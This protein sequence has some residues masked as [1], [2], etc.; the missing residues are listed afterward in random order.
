MNFLRKLT[1]VAGAATV[2]MGL[3]A[4]PAVLYAAP[5]SVSV[6]LPGD[7]P[8]LDP[9]KDTS[10]L[11]FNYRLN[12]FDALTELQRDGQMNPRLAESWTVSP[13]LLE[14]TFKLRQNVKFHDGSPFTADDVV[15][16]VERILNDSKSPVRTF[17]K[18]VKTVEKVDDN[19]V[20]FTLSAPYGIFY[21]QISYVN[22]MSKTYFDKVGDQG[23]AT[24][25]VGTG[26]YQLV[27][28]KKDDRMVLKAN[29][30]YW[31]G[32]PAIKDAT[33]RPIPADASRV[34]ALLTGEVDLVPALPP[35]LMA[36]VKASPDLNV[37]I[38]PG[39]RVIFVAFN[40]NKPPFDNPL[41]REAVDKAIDRPAI[42]D[43]LLRGLGKPTGI[44]VPPMNIGYDSSLAPTK[45]DPA[46]AKALV[47]K[48]GYKGEVISIQ[49]PNNNIVMAN[50]VVQAIAGYMTAAGL[51]VEIK[52]MEFTAFFPIW[53][54]SKVDSM[55][56]FAF[57]SSQYH[58]ES[59]LT[60]M[61]EEG[62]HAYKVDKEIDRLLKEQR[63]V[64]D[65]DKQKKL[66]VQA[67]RISNE[68]RY[69]LPL[70]DEMQAYGVKK[71]VGYNPWPDGFVRL[72]DIK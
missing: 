16:T 54:Q 17:I 45:Y 48:S 61:Y 8:G 55:Y 67:F 51:K 4:L 53:L 37:G 25:P 59:V 5:A 6:A 7:F 24:K 3:M 62:S 39:F 10:P 18:L 30:S 63:T 28:W 27:E 32:A 22:I 19:T 46:A 49:Y 69:H 68:N 21:R 34:S 15:F 12:V 70:Y 2:T 23:Y 57:G 60:T 44:M 71:T 72:Y 1:T 42:T 31:R 47:E 29:E 33:L 64:T 40:V 43:K 65:V 50:E 66:L 13:D 41:I 58:A 11:G 20:K 14:W 35:S 9:S 38:A 52:P 26:P 36:Q 56:L